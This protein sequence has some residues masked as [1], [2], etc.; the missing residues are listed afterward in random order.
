MNPRAVFALVGVLTLGGYCPAQAAGSAWTREGVNSVGWS[1]SVEHPKGRQPAVLKAQILLDRLHFSPGVIDGVYGGNT[2]K[3]LRMFQKMRGLKATGSLTKATWEALVGEDP[4]AVLTTH[5]IT[6]NEVDG[7]FTPEIP[8]S[9]KAQAKLKR[10][11]YTSPVELL[12]E[13]FHVAPKLLKRLNRGA[14]LSDAGTEIVVPDVFTEAPAEKAAKLE[15][16]KRGRELKVYDADG[17]LV[18]Y[19]PATVGSKS[20]PAPTGSYKVQS[21]SENPVYHYSPKLAFKGLENTGPFKIPAGPNNPVGAV[22]IDLSK[23]HYGIHG[24]PE[25]ATIGKTQSHGCVRLTNWDA[26][27]LAQMVHKGTSVVFQ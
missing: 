26:K 24:T 13:E 21:V 6:E 23:P 16:D 17:K 27:E 4:P 19:Y 14:E 2:R 18:A 25:P 5:K 3:A 22:W 8:G 9:M 10:L 12:S 1:R 11:G 15:I 7:P 20:N